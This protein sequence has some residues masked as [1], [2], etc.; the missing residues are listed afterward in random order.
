MRERS[1]AEDVGWTMAHSRAVLNPAQYLGE[2]IDL[3]PVS[4]IPGAWCDVVIHDPYGE[5]R[6]T[7]L[8]VQG[9]S[10]RVTGERG[11]PAPP[12]LAPRAP[13]RRAAVRPL[14]EW[15]REDEAAAA[16]SAPLFPRAAAGTDGNGS[17]RSL[18]L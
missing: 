16:S 15:E 1:R 17:S 3:P 13:G 5:M 4:G 18:R 12:R 2:F 8:V 6:W 7:F 11:N 9:A 14:R 10:L